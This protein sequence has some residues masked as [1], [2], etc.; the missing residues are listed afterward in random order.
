MKRMQFKLKKGAAIIAALAFCHFSYAQTVGGVI[1]GDQVQSTQPSQN[2]A[3]FTSQPINQNGRLLLEIQSLREELASL[4]N[5]VEQQGF[6][7]RQMQSGQLPSQN[8][9]SIDQG[10]NSQVFNNQ[11]VGEIPPG[12]NAGQN[13]GQLIEPAQQNTGNSV[14]FPLLPQDQVQQG[15]IPP[16]ATST[17][18]A[19]QN[20]LLQNQSGV[21]NPQ[22]QSPQLLPQTQNSQQPVQVIPVQPQSQVVD[23]NQAQNQVLSPQGRLLEE[24]DRG[25]KTNMNELELYNQGIDKLSS[26]EY[27]AAASIFSSQLQNFPKGE[28]AGDGYFWLG[29]TFYILEDLESAAK[30]YQTLVDRFPNHVRTPKALL[31]LIGVH[32]SREDDISARILMSILQNKYAGT[33]EANTAK[34]DYAS[35]L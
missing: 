14:Q 9:A 18:Q 16:A 26:Q 1:E 12:P 23:Q 20:Q 21:Q 24:G 10:I 19:G 35:L 6:Q 25:I 2:A 34:S 31:K 22:Q 3:N 29:E 4:R 28:K 30:S 5:Q 7:I 13:S 33:V 27:R 17:N 11:G 15:Q 8:N 32:Q